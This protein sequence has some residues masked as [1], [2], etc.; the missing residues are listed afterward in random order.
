M[1]TEHLDQASFCPFALREVSVLAELALGHLR[2]SL[3]DVPPQSNS[4]P[5]SVLEPDHAGVDWRRALPPHHHSARLER[6]TVR[7]TRI[8]TT[9]RFRPTERIRGTPERGPRVRPRERAS[10]RPGTGRIRF[11]SKPDTPRSSE[12]ILIPKENPDTAANAVLFAF[13]TISPCYRIPW[14]S[15]AQAEKKTL[16]GPLGGVFRP[17]WVTPSNSLLQGLAGV[18][19]TTTKICTDG[20]SRRAHAQTLLRSP[21]RTSYSLRLN[22]ATSAPHMPRQFCLPKL[23]HLAPSSDLRL[24]HSTSVLRAR[25]HSQ[26]GNETPR[27][28][29]RPT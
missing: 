14:N 20:G 9:H 6:N 23:A 24:H 29:E 16:P 12:P 11:P 22:D 25:L 15:N 28:C 5:G 3:T 10:T 19:A 13:R 26:I 7:P 1:R 18:F 17:L 4:P 21:P 8:S 27:E 2:Y